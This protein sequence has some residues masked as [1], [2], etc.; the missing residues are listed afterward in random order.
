MV[1][2]MSEEKEKRGRN[3][4]SDEVLEQRMKDKIEASTGGIF[5]AIDYGVSRTLLNGNKVY[6]SVDIVQWCC[7]RGHTCEMRLHMAKKVVD[8]PCKICRKEDRRLIT[9]ERI[10][11][12]AREGGA[13]LV[14]V[15]YTN[16]RTPLSWKCGC[17]N[18][19]TAPITVLRYKTI[20]CPEC[21]GF[22]IGRGQYRLNRF[23]AAVSMAESHGGLCLSSE[24]IS[25]Y[26]KMKW[27]CANGHE[28]EASFNTIK[29]GHWCRK[30]VA[31][32]RIK[33]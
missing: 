8:F 6:S 12:M 29:G 13:E 26:G 32:G 1:F 31:L 22:G 15:E 7:A 23:A 10:R 11:E 24:Y 28:W 5:K 9:V 19:F 21:R 2:I 18:T 17:G 14:S 27:C 16:V 20:K 25:S 33:K 4:V 3:P 30:C